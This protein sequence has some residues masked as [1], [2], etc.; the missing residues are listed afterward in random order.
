MIFLLKGLN[1]EGGERD[2]WE[3]GGKRKSF[4]LT[5]SLSMKY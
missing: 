3:K 4:L 5:R 1:R 2:Q